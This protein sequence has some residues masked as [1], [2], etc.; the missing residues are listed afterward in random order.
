MYNFVNTL[1]H[2]FLIGFSTFLQVTGTTIKSRM[3]SKFGQIRPCRT[4]ELAA[5]EGLEQS[6]WNYNWENVNVVTTLAPSILIESSPFLRVT[7][8]TA[9]MSSNFGQISP[10]T[11][12]LSALERLKNQCI[13]LCTL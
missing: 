13:M 10:L 5:L 2:S 6:P 8:M 11:Q 1:A 4:A 9:W 7:C 12:E 3:S